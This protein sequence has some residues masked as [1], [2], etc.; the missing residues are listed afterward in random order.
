MSNHWE[1]LMKKE[2]KLGWNKKIR[3]ALAAKENSKWKK[4]QLRRE[5][6]R[7]WPYVAIDAL[8]SERNAW[9]ELLKVGF[10]SF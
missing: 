9:Y 3:D 8:K 6:F 5:T 7:R 10:F 4:P 1:N 2:E